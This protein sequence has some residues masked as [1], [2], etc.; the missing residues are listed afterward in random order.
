M[1]AARALV[2]RG[3]H[4]DLR[5]TEAPEHAVE[6]LVDIRAQLGGVFPCAANLLTQ[7]A[8]FRFHRRCFT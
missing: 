4:I 8:E 7:Q 5:N 6:Q 3:W 2:A 1:E